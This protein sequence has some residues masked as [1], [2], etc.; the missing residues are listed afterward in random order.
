MSATNIAHR[1]AALDCEAIALVLSPLELE[2]E[3]L[4]A[5]IFGWCPPPPPASCPGHR[6]LAEALVDPGCPVEGVDREVWLH[7]RVA[8][9]SLIATSAAIRGISGRSPEHAARVRTVLLGEHLRR[10]GLSTLARTLDLARWTQTIVLQATSDAEG[11]DVEAALTRA[12]VELA[13]LVGGPRV[14]AAILDAGLVPEGREG[15]AA[16][17]ALRARRSM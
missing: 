8:D 1:L 5:A 7:L 6:R 3:V 11:P 4:G 10:E 15:R 14:V 13:R 16:V 2:R 9:E 12:A 17:A